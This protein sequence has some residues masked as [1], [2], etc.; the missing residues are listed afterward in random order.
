MAAE[1]RHDAPRRPLFHRGI[2]P[3]HRVGAGEQLR[4]HDRMV[5]TRRA[6]D[7]ALNRG[8]PKHEVDI[9]SCGRHDAVH[10]LACRH[11]SDAFVFAE[12]KDMAI[13][14]DDD[15]RAACNGAFKHAIIVGIFGDD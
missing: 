2:R 15:V 8:S 7:D 1:A 5:A 3:V 13:A 9:A 6:V 11:D 4:L 10:E 12:L 14:A